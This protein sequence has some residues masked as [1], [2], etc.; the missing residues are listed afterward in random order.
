MEL[1]WSQFVFQTDS[2]KEEG[3]IILRNSLTSGT[4][5]MERRVKQEIDKFIQKGILKDFII[6][7]YIEKLEKMKMIVPLKMDERKNYLNI[8]HNTR[9]DSSM[10][11]VYLVTTTNCQLKCCYCYEEGIDCSKKLELQMCDDI[12]SWCKNYI[13]MHPYIK[14]LRIILYGGEPLL[15]KRAIR[16]ILPRL[17]EMAKR[18]EVEFE[19]QIVTNGVLLDL[20]TALFLKEHQ[21]ERIQI[22]LDGPKNVH[23]KRRMG[24]NGRGTFEL[25]FKNILQILEA[26]IIDK[27]SLRINFDRGNV[28]YIPELLSLLSERR[29][30]S[31][32]EL[33]FGIITSTVMNKEEQAEKINAHI[34]K[35]VLNEKENVKKYLWLC[36]K[37]K[38]V[39]FT[40][41]D[42]FMT[43][44]WC[45]A[46]DIH[47]VVIES[48]GSMNK[49]F[50]GIGRKEFIF[51]NIA[52]S[53]ECCDYRLSNFSYLEKCFAKKCPY[54]PICGGGCRFEAFVHLKDI[55]Q[56]YCQF[57]LIEGI[58][59][60]LIQ[61]NY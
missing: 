41:N 7:D 27:V 24:K 60:G 6:K 33:S 5:K 32:L 37:A 36:K 57:K 9:N 20:N 59:K 52:F 47:S 8:F 22:T 44:P 45:T 31:R 29:L 19:T 49:C 18:K 30:Q 3:K 23:D 34:K 11:I 56:H 46:R 42:E 54:I 53:K 13:E 35:Y 26:Q 55:Q 39:G 48:D 12:I 4:V 58:N 16:Y 2:L 38:E 17:Y 50:S 14:K 21:L 28:N 61:L 51:G 1:K 25:I 15:N 10:F 43:G 40:I